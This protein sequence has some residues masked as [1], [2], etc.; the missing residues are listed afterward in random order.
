MLAMV[1]FVRRGKIA[2]MA[3]KFK[4]YDMNLK[5]KVAIVTGGGRDIG[6]AVAVKLAALGARVVVNYFQ[7]GEK[8][9]ETLGLIRKNGGVAVAIQ[10]DVSRWEDCIRLVDETRAVFGPE[11]HILVNNA[12]G[13]IA[14]KKLDEM[15]EAFWDQTMALNAK[16]TFM[17]QKAVK[18]YM[19]SG[20]S[21][22]N[23]ASAAGREGGGNGASAYGASKGAIMTFTRAMAKELGPEGI[24]VNCVCPGLISTIF[25]DKFTAPEIRERVAGGTPLRREGTAEEVANLI[26]FLASDEAGFITGV[27]YDI[28]GGILYS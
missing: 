21:V 22:V 13:L 9:E 14:R 25:H 11:I 19:P 6:R 17:M 5:N 26:A 23:M 18:P 16:S 8:A 7:S 15:D 12:G 10:A 28:N 24:R 1:Y 27:N 3:L 4:I 2:I 20:G